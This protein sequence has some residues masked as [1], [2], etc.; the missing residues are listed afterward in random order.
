MP[1]DEGLLVTEWLDDVCGPDGIRVTVGIE[2]AVARLVRERDAWTVPKLGLFPDPTRNVVRNALPELL[3]SLVFKNRWAVVIE[4]DSG[5]R[6]RLTRSSRD[7]ALD[8]ARS[9][10]RRVKEVG[11]PALADIS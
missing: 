2:P 8:V 11:V 5:Q 9:V 1:G 7:E 3:Q 10:W 4:A 6:R